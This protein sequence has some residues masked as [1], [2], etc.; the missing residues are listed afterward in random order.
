MIQILA[1]G[2]ADPDGTIVVYR[3]D[4]GDGNISFSRV[5]SHD[6]KTPGIFHV[7]LT[8]TDESGNASNC[9]VTV[10]V[11]DTTPPTIS[12]PANRRPSR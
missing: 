3:W 9:T 5:T 6:Y 1:L 2:S 8:V 12:P 11:V 10:T 4:F 7:T